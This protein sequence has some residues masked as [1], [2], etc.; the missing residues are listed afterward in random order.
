M[1]NVTVREAKSAVFI[2][3]SLNAQNV[4]FDGLVVN[5][6][7]EECRTTGYRKMNLSAG[8]RTLL[9]AK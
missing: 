2:D 6:R 7:R 4:V 5:G 8:T 1:E 3:P 9:G